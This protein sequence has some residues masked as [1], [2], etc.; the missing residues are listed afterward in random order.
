MVPGNSPT[1]EGISLF[2]FCR[3]FILCSARCFGRSISWDW[4]AARRDGDW[5]KHR[6]GM[7]VRL[8]IPSAVQRGLRRRCAM[9]GGV[10]E[11]VVMAPG[12]FFEAVRIIFGRWS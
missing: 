10:E 1:S 11:V 7:G 9:R 2:C 3:T 12:T 8:D 6:R 4:V 5:E